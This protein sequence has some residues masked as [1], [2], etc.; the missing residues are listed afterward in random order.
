MPVSS[1]HPQCCQEDKR[2]FTSVLAHDLVID[3]CLESRWSG[4]TLGSH[5]WDGWEK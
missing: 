3:R 4:E 1:K 5:F 2:Y